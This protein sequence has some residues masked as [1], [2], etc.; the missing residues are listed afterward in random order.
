[1]GNIFDKTYILQGSDTVQELTNKLFQRQ[2]MASAN[3][4][5]NAMFEKLHT[6]THTHTHTLTISN[7]QNLIRPKHFSIPIQTSS[8]RHDH[9]TQFLM[10]LE[11]RETCVHT[12]ALPSYYYGIKNNNI[13]V[14]GRAK[15][16][17]YV[18]LS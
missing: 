4:D 5:A 3:E 10:L 18:S 1:M 16:L 12:P 14:G 15:P 11:K 17:E 6:H 13:R 7:K 2:I 8:T 9:E